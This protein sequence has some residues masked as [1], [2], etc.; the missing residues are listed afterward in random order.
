MNNYFLFQSSEKG[1]QVVKMTMITKLSMNLT[2]TLKW[3]NTNLKHRG[4][5]LLRR[6]HQPENLPRRNQRIKVKGKSI[7]P[8]FKYLGPVS[9]STMECPT[10]RRAIV[11]CYL[12]IAEWSVGQSVVL[13]ETA[14]RSQ[15]LEFYPIFR[16][17]QKLGKG[18][19][20]KQY[21][22]R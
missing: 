11:P 15:Y 22:Y 19:A 4:D 5:H 20:I 10:E 17:V 6:K 21:N 1:W 2:Q 8:G 16:F 12:S 3:M 13:I 18:N 7:R 9:I 14:P